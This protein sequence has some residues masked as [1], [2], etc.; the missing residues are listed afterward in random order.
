MNLILRN[1]RELWDPFNRISNIE[2]ELSRLFS[3]SLGLRREEDWGPFF[4][5]DID[6]HEEEQ[7]FVVR[8][9]I[10]GIR[11]EDL[12][13]AI[14]GNVVTIKGERKGESEKKGKNFYHAERWSG[15]FRRMI[16]LPV[17]VDSTKA[18]AAVK[19]GVLE[20]TLP[21]SENAKPKQIK[22]EVK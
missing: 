15:G 21:K 13:I 14:T 2:K 16:E 11:K 8:A 6:L 3:G 1:N 5:P 7:Q 22:V 17:D 19:E 4:K 18:H 10:P 20:L 9:D 12:E